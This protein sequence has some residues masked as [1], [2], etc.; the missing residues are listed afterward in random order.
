M[1][2]YF[3][4]PMVR[5]PR[6]PTRDPRKGRPRE[7]YRLSHQE[8]QQ[9]DAGPPPPP[10]PQKQYECAAP[11]PTCP[12]TPHLPLACSSGNATADSRGY[13]GRGQSPWS[14]S[15][16]LVARAQLTWPPPI[17]TK[18]MSEK[19]TNRMKKSM[20]GVH[21]RATLR[22]MGWI[23]RGQAVQYFGILLLL[24]NYCHNKRHIFIKRL[25]FILKLI[26]FRWRSN[27]CNAEHR[28]IQCLTVVHS[29]I[30]KMNYI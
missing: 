13:R 8:T 24:Q 23:D 14:S 19:G 22:R 7:G 2:N 27:K 20:G 5:P 25:F 16:D 1:S 6:T 15:V 29:A 12:L 28:F 17:K 10:Y 4:P 18:V 26:A 30:R 9:V 3:I 21:S 11:P